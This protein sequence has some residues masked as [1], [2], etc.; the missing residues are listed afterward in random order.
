MLRPHLRG[1]GPLDGGLRRAGHWSGCGSGQNLLHGL[2]PKRLVFA[3]GQPHDPAARRC[4]PVSADAFHAVQL[5]RTPEATDPDGRTG[6]ELRRLHHFG[7]PG[8]GRLV[9]ACRATRDATG[10]LACSHALSLG[11][12]GSL[13]RR[14]GEGCRGGVCHHFRWRR[15]PLWR[16]T[17]GAR[18]GP[19]ARVLDGL[20]RQ[21]CSRGHGGQGNSGHG[22]QGNAARG[23]GRW[24]ARRWHA[25]SC[26]RLGNAHF[27]GLVE[28]R[29]GRASAG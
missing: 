29:R 18:A 24:T 25:Q 5:G 10:A 4:V 20:G 6:P 15:H 11:S 21:G 14:C 16:G 27:G 12:C 1:T 28:A 22:G 8:G 23:R 2:G 13:R 7:G 17:G 3:V 26:G 9:H 19:S